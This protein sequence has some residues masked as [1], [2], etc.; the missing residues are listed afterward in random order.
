MSKSDRSNREDLEKAF[1]IVG[2]SQEGQ[3]VLRHIFDMTGYDKS[4]L[5]ISDTGNVND[6][7]VVYGMARRELWL[8]IRQFLDTEQKIKIE[9]GG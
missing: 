7:S 3:A 9:V 4:L 1:H 6:L 5:S 2:S 8:Q